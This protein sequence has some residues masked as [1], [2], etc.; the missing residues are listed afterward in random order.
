MQLSRI[1]SISEDIFKKFVV[2]GSE[3]F[4]IKVQTD[5]GQEQLWGGFHEVL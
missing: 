3:G 1:I 4:A 2:I 5:V